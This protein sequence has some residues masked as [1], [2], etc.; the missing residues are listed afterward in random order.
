MPSL[1][2][3]NEISLGT[4]HA[5]LASMALS[6]ARNNA[7]NIHR[8]HKERISLGRRLSLEHQTCRHGDIE[9]FKNREKRACQSRE[10][11]P[12][13]GRKHEHAKSTKASSQK[14]CRRGHPIP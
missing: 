1:G 6:S 13:S 14:M 12:P 4:F 2:L 8:I 9:S 5:R 7:I 3:N 10:I 11:G